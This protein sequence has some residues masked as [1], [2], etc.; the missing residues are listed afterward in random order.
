MRAAQAARWVPRTSRSSSSARRRCRWCVDRRRNRAPVSERRRSERRGGNTRRTTRHRRTASATVGPCRQPVELRNRSAGRARRPARARR[1]DR[2]RRATVGGASSFG[3]GSGTATSPFV[4]AL[5][6]WAVPSADKRISDVATVAASTVVPRISSSQNG[7]PGVTLNIQKQADRQRGHRFRTRSSRRSGS[8]SASFRTSSFRS[9]T[10]NRR[11]PKSRS[12]GVEHT[13][14]EGIVLTARRD[15][16][17]PRLVA[18]R[19]RRHGRDPD[20]ARRDALHHGCA[21][22]HARH[23]LADGD[24]A[25]DRH[26]HRRLDRRARKHRTPSRCRRGAGRR[27]DQRPHRD[28]SGRDRDHA[29]RRR[30]VLAAGVRRRSNRHSSSTSS[31][32]SSWSRR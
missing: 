31:R 2:R 19:G 9:R 13:L 4:G 14:L 27:G 30:R 12:Q 1:H 26:P 21:G 10:C 24:D 32:S 20:L 5:Q 25:R 3:S 15:A 6:S 18:Q 17:L 22:S 23:G 11:L 29:R 16:V 8:C 28:R 7:H